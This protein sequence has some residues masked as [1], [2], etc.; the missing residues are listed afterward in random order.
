MIENLGIFLNFQTNLKFVG[1]SIFEEEIGIKLF[2][3]ITNNCSTIETLYLELHGCFIYFTKY[4]E[5]FLNSQ[6]VLTQV[7]AVIK[8]IHGGYEPLL[9]L[10]FN[11]RMCNYTN[12]PVYHVLK[13]SENNIIDELPSPKI[14]AK[15]FL[16]GDIQID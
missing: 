3:A 15:E 10:L 6:T 12:V 14:L 4:L 1:L 2:K 16:Y 8:W 7:F 9:T 5:K 13:S 11:L